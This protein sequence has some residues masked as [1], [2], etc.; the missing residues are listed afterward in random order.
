[1]F[2]ELHKEGV[3]CFFNV[4]KIIRFFPKNENTH[5]VCDASTGYEGFVVDEDYETVKHLVENS[6][7]VRERGNP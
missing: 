3:A 5:V 6:L 1:M 7:Y 4:N 2:I